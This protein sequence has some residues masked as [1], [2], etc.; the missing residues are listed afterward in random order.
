MS[1]TAAGAVGGPRSLVVLFAVVTVGFL[2]LLVVWPLVAVFEKTLSDV[3]AERL[4]EI[5]G[6]GSVR[7]ALFF[8]IWQSA[9]SAGLTLLI[10]LPIAHA[11]ARYRFRGRGLIRAAAVVPFVLPTVVVASAIDTSFE[12]LSLL[13]DRSV[14]AILA[15]HVFFNVAIVIRVVGGF[16]SSLDQRPVEAARVLGASPWAAFNSVTLPRLTPV[17]GGSALL[18]FLF[19]FTSFGVILILGGPRRAT[20]ETEIYRYAIF[21]QEFD[22]AS[23][24]ALVQL[25]VVALLA[26][27]VARLQRR[28][29]NAPQGRGFPMGRRLRSAKERLHLG[30]VVAIVLV[31]IGIPVASLV[32]ASLQIGDGYGI[33]NY[34]NLFEPISLLPVSAGRALFNSVQIAM[35]ATLVA[36]TVGVMAAFAVVRSGVMGRVLEVVVLVPL[37]VS[38]VTLGFGYL[39]AFTVLDLRRS[40]WLIPIAHAVVALP[41]VLAAVLPALRSIDHRYRHAAA[42]LG[43]SPIVVLRKIDWPLIRRAT[44]T[45]AG[46]AFAISLG[47]FGATSFLARSD[48]VFTAP[49]AIFRLLSQPGD[50]IRGRAM[51]LSVVIGVVVALVAATLEKQRGDSR[52]ML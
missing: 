44:V 35:A 30:A 5:L 4:T 38:A 49:L 26:V 18:V 10:G 31:V 47:E 50:L 32:E 16:W 46:F 19:S 24:L 34:R 3:G 12:R 22:V 41:F 25:F 45:G 14:S 17:I 42:V 39:L 27:L 11:L 15:A 52:V 48:S 40:P 51:A 13:S 2:S 37:G 8:T 20:V 6:R 33:Q 29:A 23:V 21:R 7:Q 43:A 9:L 1:R 36:T 28:Y